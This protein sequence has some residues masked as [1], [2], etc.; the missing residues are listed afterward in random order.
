MHLTKLLEGFVDIGVY[1]LEILEAWLRDRRRGHPFRPMAGRFSG[2]SFIDPKTGVAILALQQLK[3]GVAYT[4]ALI[5]T[6]AA[7]TTGKGPVGEVTS[8]DPAVTVG[9][10][11]DGQSAN[12]TI[13]AQLAGPA[14]LTWH[15]PAGAVPDFTVDVQDV[16]AP[17][18]FV[19]ASGA[20][21]DFTEGTTA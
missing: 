5:F 4:A 10:S 13:T 17:P 11:A 21:G 9:L 15:D 16:E 20:F 14:T 3:L 2:P 12:V 18:A 6:D 8:S 1:E 7:G 19:P